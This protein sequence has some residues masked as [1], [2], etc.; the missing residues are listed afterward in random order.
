V[1]SNP[2]LSA[3]NPDLVQGF[4]FPTNQKI[5]SNHFSALTA[6]PLENNITP[7]LYINILF[8]AS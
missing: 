3:T 6:S 2:T 7:Y 4:C 5:I 1:G 8:P